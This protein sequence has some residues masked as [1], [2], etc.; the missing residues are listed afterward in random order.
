MCSFTL[1]FDET[2]A[3]IMSPPEY[4]IL[5]DLLVNHTGAL[6]ARLHDHRTMVLR[7]H[8]LQMQ[9]KIASTLGSQVIH[10]AGL[11]LNEEERSLAKHQLSMSDDDEEEAA[12]RDDD[13]DDAAAP[14]GRSIGKTRLR[15]LREIDERQEKEKG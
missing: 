4:K 3:I 6:D 12:A 2:R 11:L 5:E 9:V 13:D 15:L 8:E 7:H 14:K 10:V 1:L